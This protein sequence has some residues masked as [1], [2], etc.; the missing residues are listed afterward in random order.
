[1][2]EQTTTHGKSTSAK[3]SS[4]GG[5][6]F[7]IITTAL[8][9]FLSV[10]LVLLV[11]ENR[12][13]EEMLVQS[14]VIQR[15]DAL[16]PG[17]R[18]SDIAI[19][20]LEGKDGLLT[21]SGEDDRYLLFVLSTSCPHCLANLPKWADINRRVAPSGRFVV[22]LSVHG[23]SET[24]QY[25]QDN[26]VG[27]YTVTT[28]DS[29]FLDHYRLPGVPATLLLSAGGVV[30]NVWIGELTDAQVAEVVDQSL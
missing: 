5:R 3:A 29:S 20:T 2:T 17:E 24:V 8:I 23:A 11:I 10:E 14:G 7:N 21:F 25:V 26:G 30:K 6:W 4:A 28:P 12:R 19:T 15:D 18:I 16:K 27:F 13:Y 22:G 1:M 9:V